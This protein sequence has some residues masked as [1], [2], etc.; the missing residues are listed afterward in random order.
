MLEQLAVEGGG[1]WVLAKIDVDA[2]PR[3]AQMFRVQSIPMVFAVVGGQPFD[4]FTGVQ[5]EA[6]IRQWHRRGAQ[7]RR[8]SRSRRRPTRGWRPPTTP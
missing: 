3:I 7:G 6:Q 5:P 4:L 1:A 8:A 2:N